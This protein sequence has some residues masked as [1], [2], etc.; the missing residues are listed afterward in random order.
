MHASPL[1][2]IFCT[3]AATSAGNRHQAVTAC[4]SSLDSTVPSSTSMRALS[5][6][7]PGASLMTLLERTDSPRR[8]DACDACLTSVGVDARPTG[9][10]DRTDEGPPPTF[11]LGVPL[12]GDE[13]MAG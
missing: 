6:R 7:T 13:N 4:I 10:A 1:S 11:R 3:A 8:R 9:V 5:L 12:E 2:P